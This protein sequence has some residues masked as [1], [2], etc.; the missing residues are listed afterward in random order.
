MFRVLFLERLNERESKEAITRPLARFPIQF[1]PETVD[2][3]H[4]RSGGYPYFV[5]FLCREMFDVYVAQHPRGER[6]SAPIEEII[7]RLDTDFFAGRWGRASD[8]QR[9]LMH[10]IAKLPN[11]DG[12]FSVK[13][14]VKASKE[15]LDIKPFSGSH[16]NQML[17]SL[18]ALG[19]VFKNRHGKYSF[20]VPLLHEFINRQDVG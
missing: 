14:I 11:A 7:K 4:R 16:I 5:Q 18:A 20:A 3:I 1:K 8:R 9:E 19:L 15:T 10:I 12:E 2:L 17:A 13:E 6:V